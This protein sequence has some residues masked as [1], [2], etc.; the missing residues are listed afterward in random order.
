MASHITGTA[1]IGEPLIDGAASNQFSKVG[2]TNRLTATAVS[3]SSLEP[4]GGDAG[5]KEGH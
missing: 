5:A 4:S 3:R 2:V 1:S